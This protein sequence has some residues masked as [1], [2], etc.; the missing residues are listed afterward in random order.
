[1]WFACA[2]AVLKSIRFEKI[3]RCKPTR[4]GDTVL[5]TDRALRIL[6]ANESAQRML[7]SCGLPC[8]GS[9][10]G[11]LER[12][13]IEELVEGVRSGATPLADGE[14]QVGSDQTWTVTVSPGRGACVSLIS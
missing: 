1:M 8:C 13:G 6:Q 2:Y 10:E 12:L 11:E 7:D 3:I 14:T 5:L 9:L 4:G